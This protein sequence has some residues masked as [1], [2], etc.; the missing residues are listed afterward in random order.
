M[1]GDYSKHEDKFGIGTIVHEFSHTL[2][3]LICIQQM[4]ATILP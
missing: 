3:L 4:V 2:G 1:R